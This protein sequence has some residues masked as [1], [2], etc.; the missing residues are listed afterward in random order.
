MQRY[1]GLIVVRGGGAVE[2]DRFDGFLLLSMKIK[3]LMD[4]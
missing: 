4:S 2:L 1:F 3:F